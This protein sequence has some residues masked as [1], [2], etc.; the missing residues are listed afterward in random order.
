MRPMLTTAV[1]L[2]ALAAPLGMAS[3][4]TPPAGQTPSASSDTPAQAQPPA[5]TQPQQPA[6]APAQNA[7]LASPEQEKKS[8]QTTSSPTG[9][10]GTQEGIPDNLANP[11]AAPALV[12]GRL[13]VPGAPQDSE[14][15]P[16]KFSEKNAALDKLPLV[17]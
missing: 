14:T 11:S 6:T 9:K 5:Q 13:N 7:P 12:N 15:V 8:Q 17:R 1:A 4:Q 3:G 16:A 10:A 2:I